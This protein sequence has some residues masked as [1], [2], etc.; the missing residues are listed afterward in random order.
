METCKRFEMVLSMEKCLTGG[1]FVSIDKMDDVPMREASS[2]YL[3]EHMLPNIIGN[4]PFLVANTPTNAVDHILNDPLTPS[5]PPQNQIQ[6]LVVPGK[7]FINRFFFLFMFV[8]EKL[9]NQQQLSQKSNENG[10]VSIVRTKIE[11]QK[12]L[13]FRRFMHC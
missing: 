2:D 5:P 8:I 13:H 12:I 4:T 11:A 3:D 9:F 6:P 7:Y 10:F 1:K